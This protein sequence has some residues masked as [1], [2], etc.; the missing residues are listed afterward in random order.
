M[1]VVCYRIDQ[2]QLCYITFKR[3]GIEKGQFVNNIDLTL[4]YVDVFGS[5]NSIFFRYAL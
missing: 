3:K 5:L 4:G 2:K 1:D